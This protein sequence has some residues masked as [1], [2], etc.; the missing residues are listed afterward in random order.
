MPPGLAAAQ[1]VHAAIQTTAAADPALLAAYLG[2]GGGTVV[3]L[4]APDEAALNRAQQAAV[5]AGLPAHLWLERDFAPP[6]VTALGLGPAP[7]P[8]LRAITRGLRPM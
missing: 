1:A 7:R 5:D 3:V 4:V 2:D 8:A 6:T